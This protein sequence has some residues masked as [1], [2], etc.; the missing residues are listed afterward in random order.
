M[1]AIS[2]KLSN[3]PFDP[4]VDE[5]DFSLESSGDEPIEDDADTGLPTPDDD[6]AGF[7]LESSGDE[8]IE[9]DDADTSLPIPGK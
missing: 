8:P 4:S 6:G 5:A 1:K 3:K 7:S 2:N 9:D